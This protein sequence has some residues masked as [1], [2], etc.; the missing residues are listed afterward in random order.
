MPEDTK[1]A[2]LEMGAAGG[3]VLRG[4]LIGFMDMVGLCSILMMTTPILGRFV[5]EW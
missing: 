1:M 4:Q 2:V 3:D 5:L